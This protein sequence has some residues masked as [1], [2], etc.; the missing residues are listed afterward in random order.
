MTLDESKMLFA[1]AMDM[2]SDKEAH[3]E[4]ENVLELSIREKI[5]VYDAEYISLASSLGI[6][7]V[8]ADRELIGKLPEIAVSMEDFTNGGGFRFVKEKKEAYGNKIKRK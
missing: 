5:S 8:T 2:L 4:P 6:K 7:L 1:E 3:T